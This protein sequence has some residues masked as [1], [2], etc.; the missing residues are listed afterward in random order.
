MVTNALAA[1]PTAGPTATDTAPAA[2]KLPVTTVVTNALAAAPTAGP[3]ATVRPPK[4]SMNHPIAQEN[5]SNETIYSARKEMLQLL[6]S[7]INISLSLAGEPCGQGDLD[8]SNRKLCFL[9]KHSSAADRS[10]ILQLIERELFLTA[11]SLNAYLSP[12][13]LRSRILGSQYSQCFTLGQ[14]QQYESTHGSSIESAPPANSTT[15]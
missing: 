3:T 11:P 8:C 7:H 4:T 10:K 14:E 6:L 12:F 15:T 2:E 5:L 9:E 1:A 13:T